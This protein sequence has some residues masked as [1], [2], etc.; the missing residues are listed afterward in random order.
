M[1]RRRVQARAP[2]ALSRSTP[3]ARPSRVVHHAVRAESVDHPPTAGMAALP[4]SIRS[5]LNSVTLA[6]APARAATC[7][8]QHSQLPTEAAPLWAFATWEDNISPAPP[9]GWSSRYVMANGIRVHYWRTPGGE[10]SDGTAKPVIVLA[11]GYADCGLS[12]WYAM[13]GLTDEFELIALD[14]RGHGLS[15][16][17]DATTP[18]DAQAKDIAAVI[19]ELGLVK[20]IVMGHSMGAAA[21]MWFAAL[22]PDVPRAVV[23]EDPGLSLARCVSPWPLLRATLL[24]MSVVRVKRC[25]G[26][27][28][29]RAFGNGASTKADSGPGG[30]S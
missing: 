18:S 20:P 2:R 26:P 4:S 12:W 14:A 7:A 13:H 16:P 27:G 29:A 25:S 24:Q 21:A 23:L 10:R 9:T 22:F 17:P 8:A 1:S 30:G 11:H 15:D 5:R 28:Q 3:R 19:Q 6:L